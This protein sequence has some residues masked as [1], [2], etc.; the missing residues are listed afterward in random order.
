[1]IDQD[2]LKSHGIA[3][4]RQN[5]N[6]RTFIETEW[7]DSNSAYNSKFGSKEREQSSVLLGQ[8]RIFIPK[9]YNTVQ[10][11]L[12]E[13]METFFFDS[14]EIVSVTG[15]KNK[16]ITTES[17]LAV[18]AILNYRLNG[19]PINA[20]QEFY[21]AVLDGLKNKIGVLKVYPKLRIVK[22]EKKKMAK[23]DDG[24]EVEV[25]DTV[26]KVDAF[27]PRIECL[28]PEDVFLD[29]MATWKDYW[30]YPIVHRI[31]K[32][33]DELKRGGFKN[34]DAVDEAKSIFANESQ[35]IDRNEAS[36]GFVNRDVEGQKQ[37]FDYEIWT[38]LDINDDGKLEPVV[39]HMLGNAD[40]PQVIGIDPVENT[41]PYK[42]G[43]FEMVRP[44]FVIGTPFPEPH[45]MHGKDVPGFTSGLQKEINAL[46]NQDREAAALS[47]RKPLL[48]N[49]D[50]GVDM[51]ALINRKI[52]AP[53][54]ADE[55]GPDA[56]RELQ[57]SNPVINTAPVSARID[58]DYFEATSITPGQLGVSVRDET[59]T[60]VSAYQNN[61][62]KKIQNIIRN[63]SYT[64]FKPAMDYLLRLEQAYES[65]FFI[66]KV[67]GIV[68][69]WRFPNDGIPD[70]QKIQGDYELSVDVGINKQ[71]QLNR[72]LLLMDRMNQ[73]NTAIMQLMQA[74]IIRPGTV[75]L[76][77]PM[78]AFKRASEVLKHKN[79]EEMF[80]EAAPPVPQGNAP[81]IASQPRNVNDPA[82]QVG[83]MNPEALNEILG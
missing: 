42:F 27:E 34:I 60:A 46:R 13:I 9:T 79:T 63:L 41:L 3:V 28:P 72:Y 51:M 11:M 10:R 35:K 47:I 2:V 58:Q 80:L 64:L 78:W 67:T 21:E 73:T 77:N 30:K 20:Y 40:G 82:Q 62:N 49:R 45:K 75:S 31:S 68:L 23:G 24:V 6:A 43:E 69:G 36:A 52:G 32:T 1:M 44:P 15:G 76:L 65:D 4:Y 22:E 29:P 59:A 37:Y 7:S 57:M 83:Q 18:K 8:S 54:M 74:G 26:Q 12:T 38:F 66:Q 14:D 19:H 39:Y 25:V 70:W 56:V 71:S 81:G 16:S 17:V 53:V 61:A 50:A 55:T 33:K 48:V 5:K